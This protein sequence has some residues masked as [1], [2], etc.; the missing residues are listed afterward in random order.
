MFTHQ[1]NEDYVKFRNLLTSKNWTYN[2]RQL[3][4]Q[5]LYSFKI[6]VFGKG[7]HVQCKPGL[8]FSRIYIYIN[9]N[10]LIHRR[11]TVSVELRYSK[12]LY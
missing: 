11:K 4:I 3:F 8:N 10:I 7:N 6:T 1:I 9:H 12:K 2:F 5:I